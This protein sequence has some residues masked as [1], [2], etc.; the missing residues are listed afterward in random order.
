MSLRIHFG[1]RVMTNLEPHSIACPLHPYE[2]PP[3]SQFTIYLPR[4]FIGWA[5]TTA[6]Q[7]NLILKTVFVAANGHRPSKEK[8][9]RSKTPLAYFQELSF[10]PS[11]RQNLSDSENRAVGRAY[12]FEVLQIGQ[13]RGVVPLFLSLFYRHLPHNL[14]L[15]I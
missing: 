1:V 4:N 12:N 2:L 14:L 7:R 5:K 6:K 11:F 3:G 10:V 13:T 15:T 8:H 9:F